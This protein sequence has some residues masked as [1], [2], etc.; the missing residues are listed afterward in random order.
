M[1]KK[2][3]RLIFAIVAAVVTAIIAVRIAVKRNGLTLQEVMSNGVS[4]QVDEMKVPILMYHNIVSDPTLVGKYVLSAKDLE[5]DIVYLKSHGFTIVSLKMLSEFCNAE[6]KN[7]VKPVVL[8]FDDGCY[9]MLTQVL[10]ILKK[11]GVCASVSVVGRYTEAAKEEAY[12]S[13][14]YS[15]LDS[16]DINELLSSGLIELVDHSYD[17]HSLDGRR[18]TLQLSTESYEDYRRALLNDTFAAQRFFKDNCG[19]T[20]KAYAY[21]FG[22]NC[23]AGRNVISMC[24]FD[25]VLGVEE[26]INVIRKGDPKS[27]FLLGRFN[28]PSGISTEEFMMRIE[29]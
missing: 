11:H 24:G 3:I 9:S 25:V 17:M 1:I 14:A 12:P 4:A 7:I 21:P 2:H 26:K 15:Y 20:P 13:E 6:G 16:D 28:R 8:T 10:P 5:S 29:Q 18:G 19:V 23:S 27:L 22:L